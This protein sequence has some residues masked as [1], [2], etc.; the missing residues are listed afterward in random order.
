MAEIR[1]RPYR[2]WE[3]F[4]D[5]LGP[6]L[7]DDQPFT[8]ERYLFRGVRDADWRLESSFDRRFGWAADRNALADRLLRR[9]RSA[10]EDL[11]DAEL[12][13]DDER[14][15]ALGQHNELPTRLLDW[16]VSPYVAAFFALSSAVVRSSSVVE[17]AAVWALHLDAPI[18]DT[19]DGVALL[20]RPTV[21]NARLRNQG[22]RFTR[23]LGPFA[24]VDEYVEQ[25]R[26]PGPGL[27]KLL[28]PTREAER[29]LAHLHMMGITAGRLFPDLGGAARTAVME[30][31]MAQSE[32][33]QA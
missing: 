5:S 12:L 11:V 14:L 16:T 31:R 15:L 13:A 20:E 30:V 24:S 22:G 29:G 27:T 17:Y 1:V 3:Q 18:W 19:P 2:S 26:E 6:E 32:R 8:D 23:M 25:C 9:F 33:V 28:I 10:C 7:F 4:A 21:G